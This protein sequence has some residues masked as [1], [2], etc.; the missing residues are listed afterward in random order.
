MTTT[1]T[2]KTTTETPRHY[3]AWRSGP[4]AGEVT[5][6]RKGPT[7]KTRRAAL[8]WLRE[9]CGELAKVLIC[10]D[11]ACPALDLGDDMPSPEGDGTSQPSPSPEPDPPRTRRRPAPQPGGSPF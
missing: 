11:A 8:S 9:R 7:F 1:T 5:V 2:E 6:L 4:T 10:R 3:H